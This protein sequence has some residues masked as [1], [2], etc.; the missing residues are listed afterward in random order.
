MR[1]FRAIP[2][3]GLDA[4]EATLKHLKENSSYYLECLYT[5][6][7]KTPGIFGELETLL[8]QPNIL[9]M[10][11]ANGKNI[12]HLLA[13][14]KGIDSL[15]LPVLRARPDF[16]TAMDG[17]GFTVAIHA[18]RNLN[19]QTLQQLGDAF[20][21]ALHCK[22]ISGMPLSFYVAG[23]NAPLKLPILRAHGVNIFEKFGKSDIMDM[24]CRKYMQTAI[25]TSDQV[26]TISAIT[27]A[28]IEQ[29]GME[30]TVARAREN[31]RECL[32]LLAYL[33]RVPNSGVTINEAIQA[34]LKAQP[35]VQ[36]NNS[37]GSNPATHILLL[38]L[39]SYEPYW[40]LAD[41]IIMGEHAAKV[42]FICDKC[43]D[44]NCVSSAAN[45]Q[46]RLASVLQAFRKNAPTRTL[47]TGSSMHD[48]ITYMH[49]HTRTP[50]PVASPAL[51][52]ALLEHGADIVGISCGWNSAIDQIIAHNRKDIAQVVSD[53]L[54]KTAVSS[55]P[56][57]N[58]KEI[59]RREQAK[60]D[61]FLGLGIT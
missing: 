38:M 13:E 4:F 28:F 34:I 2:T 22:D 7:H 54:K 47:D 51:F 46:E 53:H 36:C 55:K 57:F 59:I 33:S 35:R 58:Q 21:Q 24:A 5:Y 52:A 30:A 19:E 43:P 17:D 10:K 56:G 48:L 20:P 8:C 42:D 41:H 32:P 25:P 39:Y 23:H 15:L 11:T 14:Y 61:T 40:E 49:N 31:P 45:Q 6:L 1:A 3:T 37:E 50:G 60:L 16:C 44:A 27:Y 29:Y 12:A 26:Q 18:A 9:D